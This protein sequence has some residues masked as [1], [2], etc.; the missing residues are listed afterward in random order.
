MVTPVLIP[1]GRDNY[2]VL[3]H[4]E[5]THE[6][7]LIDAPVAEPI[8]REGAAR[9]WSLTTILITHRHGDHIAGIDGL[10][11]HGPATLI[12]P[13]D[14]RDAVPRADRYVTEGARIR[15]GATEAEVWSLPGHCADHV[16]YWIAADALFFAGDVLFTMGCGRPLDG[17]PA[18]LYRSLKRLARLPPET[19][20]YCGHE[21]SLANARFCARMAPEDAAIAARLAKIEAMRGQSIPC[22]P[23][24]IG[25][26]LA[27]TLFLRAPDLSEFIRLREA[28]SMS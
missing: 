27:T 6:T 12:A 17:D 4:C 19:R 10:L 16:G 3:L 15:I 22:V 23:T 7:T 21:Y 2:A 9:G 11:A 8:L 5:K 25:E 28:K 1:I 24:T 18:A 20:V 26:E 14:A 13:E